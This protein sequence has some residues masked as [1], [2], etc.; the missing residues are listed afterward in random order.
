VFGATVTV[1]VW[2]EAEDFTVIVSLAELEEA[3]VINTV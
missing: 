2:L 1:L 3:K